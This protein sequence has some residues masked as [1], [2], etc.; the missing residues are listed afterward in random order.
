[1]CHTDANQPNRYPK[2][3]D[4]EVGWRAPSSIWLSGLV[5]LLATA[6]P[7]WV[8]CRYEIPTATNGGDVA[9]GPTEGQAA[10]ND[11]AE[12]R[13]RLSEQKYE[14]PAE[15]DGTLAIRLLYFPYLNSLRYGNLCGEEVSETYADGAIIAHGLTA[16]SEWPEA[17]VEF[18]DQGDGFSWL[19]YEYRWFEQKRIGLFTRTR[20][21]PDR[22]V[23]AAVAE[24]VLRD[25][26]PPAWGM[27]SAGA[28]YICLE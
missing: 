6:S 11:Q 16:E 21:G 7:L 25:G 9:P 22:S 1:M 12:R 3:S 27:L 18:L 28:R 14:P 8:G 19:D 20:H 23:V 2:E 4:I 15:L 26:D 5:A 10:V 17:L 24:I 13:T